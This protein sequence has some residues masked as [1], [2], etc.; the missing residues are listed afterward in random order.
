[1]R[2]GNW[3]GRQVVP[4]SW[5][6][7]STREQAYIGPDDYVG[8]LDR[9]F[10][11]LFSVFPDLKYYGYLGMAGQELFILPEQDMVVA[12]T[13]SLEVGKEGRLL[14]LVNDYILPAV[15]SEKAIPENP[16]AAA[17][18]EAAIQAAAGSAQPVPALP[19]TALDISGKTYVLEENPFAWTD[20]TFI[21][22]PGA[23]EATLKM[24]GSPD[25]SIGLD[26][27][28]RLTTVPLGRPVGLRGHW[29]TPDELYVDFVTVG[30]LM[31]RLV[32]FK[33]AG[34][35]VTVTVKELNFGNPAVVVQGMVGE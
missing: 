27:R 7:D 32:R 18:L 30:E 22:Q 4:A 1:L 11:Y 33:F 14:S 10:G 34:D 25:F 2:K 28:Y 5:V 17:K 9:R 19:Q 26:N 20:M 35:Q 31:E 21:F 15:R 12:F 6:A 23:A 3:D 13:S 8:G 29:E 16:Q 24:S